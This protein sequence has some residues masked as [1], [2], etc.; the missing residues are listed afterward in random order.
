MERYCSMIYRSMQMQLRRCN[1]NEACM[2][3]R[4][5]NSFMIAYRHWFK[6]RERL[7]LYQFKSEKQE[8]NF[9]KNCKPQF[10]SEIEYYCLVYHSLLFQPL[11]GEIRVEF[12]KRE[13][14]RL[15]KFEE[16]NSE[17]LTCYP[18]NN[19]EVLPF[20]FLRKYYRY[21]K[22][23]QIK[24]YDDKTSVTN[25]DHPVTMLL[26]LRKYKEYVASTNPDL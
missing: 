21:D 10:T 23:A 20:Y 6:I 17:F 19:C 25:G 1:Q 2:H 26:A 9:F 24:M 15:Q 8:I 12:W 14:S 16:E 5:E 13:Y 3:S 18:D 11:D 7:N 22:T 4:I